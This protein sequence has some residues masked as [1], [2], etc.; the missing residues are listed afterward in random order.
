MGDG[1]RPRERAG[2]VRV[3]TTALAVLVVGVALLIGSVLM[4]S[5]LRRS[6]TDNVRTAALVRAETVADF[7][8][9]SASGDPI[10]VGDKEEEFVQAVD[11]QGQVVA[12]SANVSGQS[13]VLRLS[14]GET[15]RIE[16]TPF[17]DA[18]FEPEAFIVVATSADVASGPVTVIVGRSLDTVAESTA[19]TTGLLAVGIPLLLLVVGVVTWLVVG[20][21]L[22]PVESIRS[23]VEAISTRELHRRVPDPQG[24]DEIA[25]LARTMNRMLGRLEE[26]QAR[27][28]RFVSDASHELRSPVAT[29]REH[30]EIALAHPDRLGP[31]ELAEVVLE[32][33]L[34]IQRLVEDL[35]LLTRAD[36]GTLTHRNEPVDLDDLVLAE[37]S[38]LNGS[39]TDVRVDPSQVSAGRVLGDPVQLD[40]LVRNVFENAVRHARGVVALSL[41]RADGEVVLTVDDD[42][43]GI[44]PGDRG[45]IFDRFVRLEEARDRDSGGSGLGLAIVR[46]IAL[47]HG[48]T[49]VVS[50]SSLGGARFE[51][52]FPAHPG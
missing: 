31:E 16:H 12:S 22:A 26:G 35:L 37:A 43:A 2:S 44:G 33:N 42:G 51:I 14:P 25:R 49:V 15:G 19:T 4:V 34:R 50:E 10:S 39:R 13:P 52:R 21:A 28:R 9:S 45:R 48:A 32:E 5:L 36:E 3:R 38:R 20:R 46:E 40:R 17:E 11:A 18:P 7:L 30:A 27:Q 47:A 6:L 29:I 23:E 1:L 24:N 41:R 8:R